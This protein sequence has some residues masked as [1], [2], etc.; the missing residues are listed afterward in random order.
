MSEYMKDDLKA[1]GFLSAVE[2]VTTVRLPS[3]Q[4]HKLLYNHCKGILCRSDTLSGLHENPL[5]AE[6]VLAQCQR[7]HS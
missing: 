2:S 7:S 6:L 5:P 4:I 1:S 3:N